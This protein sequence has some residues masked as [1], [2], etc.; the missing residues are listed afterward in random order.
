VGAVVQEELLKTKAAELARANR[1]NRTRWSVQKGGI[2]YA[3]G[4]R[5]M[6]R[7]RQEDDAEAKIRRAQSELEYVQKMARQDRNK[8][9]SWCLRSLNGRLGSGI[10]VLNSSRK[11]RKKEIKSGSWFFR[12]LSGE[13]SS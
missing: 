5:T 8:S 11:W 13:C 6:V 9:G 4:S 2:L 10:L 12:S 7:K 3:D 1:Q